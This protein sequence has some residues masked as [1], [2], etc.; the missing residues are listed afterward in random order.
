MRNPRPR[1]GG[2]QEGVREGGTSVLYCCTVGRGQGPGQA[3]GGVPGHKV[4]G[5]HWLQGAIKDGNCSSNVAS[6]EKF[7]RQVLDALADWVKKGFA[8]G[9]FEEEEVPEVDKTSRIM[10]REKVNG[11]VSNPEFVRTTGDVSERQDQ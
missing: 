3:V 2:G 7:G 4:W 6:A 11:S 5:R 9:P 8:A 1:G 10:C